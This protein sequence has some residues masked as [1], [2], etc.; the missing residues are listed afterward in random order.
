[1]FYKLRKIGLHLA[2][3]FYTISIVGLSAQVLENENGKKTEE[4]SGGTN[5]CT[6]T[7]DVPSEK[8]INQVAEMTATLT[9][10]TEIIKF[11]ITGPNDYSKEFTSEGKVST[12]TIF[13]SFPEKGNYSIT[14]TASGATPQQGTILIY[15]DYT[16]ITEKDCIC[17]DSQVKAWLI[18]C[19]GNLVDADWRGDDI[20]FTE[21]DGKKAV[22]TAYSPS[23]EAGDKT[24]IAKKNG[25]DYSK[26]LT[27][28]HLRKIKPEKDALFE[29]QSTIIRST[30]DPDCPGSKAH[31]TTDIGSFSPND[32][33]VKTIEENNPTWYAPKNIEGFSVTANIK[34]LDCG[35][36]SYEKQTKIKVFNKG[37][38]LVLSG[39]NICEN[40][41]VTGTAYRI[42]PQT[43]RV[44]TPAVTW[45]DTPDNRINFSKVINTPTN[46]IIANGIFEDGEVVTITIIDDMGQTASQNVTLYKKTKLTG[47]PAICKFQVQ[48]YELHVC[49]GGQYQLN[50]TNTNANFVVNG[51]IARTLTPNL[52]DNQTYKFQVFGATP[53]NVKIVLSGP[54]SAELPITITDGALI[55]GPPDICRNKPYTY[56]ATVC[57]EGDY[58]IESTPSAN[59]TIVDG[60]FT[61]PKG[62]GTFKFTFQASEVDSY[63][64]QIHKEADSDSSGGP[65]GDPLTVRVSTGIV[66][67]K[68]TNHC[69]TDYS[70]NCLEFDGETCDPALQ[71]QQL[72]INIDDPTVVR[73]KNGHPGTVTGAAFNFELVAVGEGVAKVTV[74]GGGVVSNEITVTVQDARVKQFDVS[75]GKEWMDYHHVIYGILINEEENQVTMQVQPKA[76]GDPPIVESWDFR[77]IETVGPCGETVTNS[78]INNGD[79]LEQDAGDD[80]IATLTYK[81]TPRYRYIVEC[82]IKCPN[83]NDTFIVFFN[84][85][86]ELKENKILPFAPSSKYRSVGIHGQ[87]Q[88]AS[89][90][91]QNSET[92]Q[93]GSGFS[94]DAYNLSATYST[95][96]VSVPLQS[97]ELRLE[98]RRT[99]SPDTKYSNLCSFT[100]K[101]DPWK[102]I[103]GL[104][105]RT[106]ITAR[107]DFTEEGYTV[108]DENGSSY[109][110]DTF[111]N[112]KRETFSNQEAA[113]HNLEV[114]D[115]G[116]LWTKRYGTKYFFTFVPV[117]DG[118]IN[119]SGSGDGDDDECFESSGN[120]Q[121]GS[122]PIKAH[123][124]IKDITDRNNNKLI[125]E[126]TEGLL[127][128]DRI[129]YEQAPQLSIDFEY[130]NG[131]LHTVTDPMGRVHEYTFGATGL[132]TSVKQPLVPV[133]SE[134][135]PK[136]DPELVHPEYFYDYQTLTSSTGNASKLFVCL[137]KVTDPELNEISLDYTVLFANTSDSRVSL[138]SITSPDGEATFEPTDLI[139]T[140][141]NLITD[142][143]GHEWKY[144][145]STSS[146]TTAQGQEEFLLDQFTRTLNNNLTMTAKFGRDQTSST[147]N[148]TEV[149]DYHGNK[150]QYQY[151][152]HSVTYHKREIVDGLPVDSTV[153]VDYDFGKYGQ[154]YREVID[155]DGL[156][157]TKE[158]GY[159][160]DFSQMVK[161]VDPRGFEA[162]NLPADFTTTYR[163]DERGN[164]IAEFAPENKTTLFAF[165]DFGFQIAVI[166]ADGRTT[167]ST[168]TYDANG[169][170][171][172]SVVTGYDNELAITTSKECD[173][174]GNVLK[175]VDGNGNETV[176]LFDNLNSLMATTFPQVKDYDKNDNLDNPV[177]LF[178]RDK[179]RQIVGKLDPRGNWI[180]TKYDKMLRP[181]Q[182]TVEFISEPA[183]NIVTETFYDKTGN[184][185]EFIDARGVKYTFAYD[186]FNNLL[187]EV[188]DVGE[189]EEF[190][191]LTSTYVYGDDSG[192]DLFGDSGFVPTKKT[193]ARG[194]VTLLEYDDAYRLKRTKRGREGNEVLLSQIDYDAAGN[195]RRTITFNDKISNFDGDYIDAGVGLV[196]GDQ[197]TITLYDNLNRPI[198]TAVNLNGEEADFTDTG[199]IITQTFYDLAGNVVKV[200]DPE[201]HSTQTEYDGAG[202]VI[203]QVVNLDYNET[204]KVDNP[205]ITSAGG[206][207]F[208][209]VA[210]AEDIVTSKTYDDNSN[211]LTETIHNDTIG[212]VGDQVVTKTY[213]ALN[214]VITVTDPEGYPSEEVGAQFP[215]GFFTET[216]YDLNN[217]VRYV[218][219]ARGFETVTEYDEAN[220][221]FKQILPA[222]ENAEAAF[223]PTLNGGNGGFPSESPIVITHFDTNSNVVKTVDARGLV[224]LNFY[225]NLNRLEETRQI[226]DVND[227]TKDLV[228]KNKYD[229]N[230][231]LVKT[232]F[233]R[234][235]ID[236]DTNEESNTE[237][238]TTT[239]Y[240]SLDRPLITTDPEG[241]KSVVFCDLVG[242]KVKLFDKRANANIDESANTVPQLRYFTQVEFDLANRMV[243]NT[244]PLIPVAVRDIME[245]VNINDSQPFSEVKYLK[246]NWVTETKDLNG[247]I[248]ET[249]YDGAGRKKK[250]TT[251]IDQITEFE[252]DKSSNVLKQTVYNNNSGGN[253]ITTYEYDKRNLLLKEKLNEG[254]ALQR[255]YS[256]RYDENGNKLKR[257]FPNGDVTEYTYDALDRLR[258]EDYDQAESENREYLYNNNGA[259]VI[260]KDETG[261]TE[262]DH[263]ILGR[264]I[265]ETKKDTLGNILTIVESIYD[266]ANNRIRCFFPNNKKTLVSF[267][268]KRNLIKIMKG[269]HGK[270]SLGGESGLPVETTTY[271]YN[272]NGQQVSCTTPNGQTTTKTY[273][274]AD[275]ILTSTTNAN[276]LDIYTVTYKRDAVGNQL[277]TI[278]TRYDRPDR[279]LGFIYDNVYRLI[280]EID[281]VSGAKIYTEYEYDL[282][283][284]RLNK[285]IKDANKVQTAI[286]IYT[287]DKLNRT[288]IVEYK[289][290][291]DLIKTY[292]YD[293]DDN[294]NRSLKKEIDEVNGQTVVDHTYTYD[295]ENRLKTVEDPTGV[296]FTASYDY[297][298][299]RT[300][301]EEGTSQAQTTLKKT[302]YIYDGGVTCQETE[303]DNGTDILVKQYI[304][305]NGMGGGIGSVLY[306]ERVQDTS[307]SSAAIQSFYDNLGQGTGTNGSGLIAEYYAY[308]AVGSVV[309]NT[310]QDGYVIREN[311][312]DAYGNQIREQDWSS[313]NFPIEFGGSQNDLLFSTKERDFST[314][315]DYFGY[316]YYDAV[317][318]KFTTRDPS[319][320]PDGPNNY[321]Y[322][323]NNPI[324]SLD[325]L[326]LETADGRAF[327]GWV[328]TFINHDTQE[329]YVGSTTAEIRRFDEDY[330]I[331]NGYDPH[332]KIEFINQKNTE[333][334]ID[335][336]YADRD[337]IKN[338]KG[339][340]N[341]FIQPTVA[342]EQERINQ[343]KYEIAND[344]KYKDYTLLNKPDAMNE[345]KLK[346]VKEHYNP[347]RNDKETILFKKEGTT[348]VDLTN[349]RK[350]RKANDIRGQVWAE[351]KEREARGKRRIR[352]VGGILGLVVS[353]MAL[354][355][356]AESYEQLDHRAISKAERLVKDYVENGK[357]YFE[358]VPYLLEELNLKEMP[359]G[360]VLVPSLLQQ[361]REEY[362][363]NQKNKVQEE[364]NDAL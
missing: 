123:Y 248:T 42:N 352:R 27:V 200:I 289:E 207:D 106:N 104:G 129:Y 97:S 103:M 194:L 214:R 65:V 318:G 77:R 296:I 342:M 291:N 189:G 135:A 210:A 217:N 273:D 260:A 140:R 179:N 130:I 127:F 259:V 151:G 279:K 55:S 353:W 252:Y 280:T 41:K 114:V 98:F 183:K 62:G 359:G 146:F 19:E 162:G 155:P 204:T 95:T 336:V 350:F 345:T 364:K 35:S 45:I 29:G 343:V 173:L 288:D 340:Q 178:H 137:S 283:G 236:P 89:R 270:V 249:E 233:I 91:Q 182:V 339:R 166:D 326:G 295:R 286:Y 50:L 57:E 119:G 96:D 227:D 20:T 170:I 245:D 355:S 234:N 70:N 330:Q 221:A 169:W 124:R 297:R 212:A 346:K 25:K 344:P 75:K 268:D 357:G 66:L 126:Y 152:V 302:N 230:N 13:P 105:W 11:N 324:N 23:D 88:T 110:Y 241:F 301:K 150:V 264:Q 321:L 156:A 261:S 100:N 253:Q 322:V 328:Y 203:K 231:N 238:I 191:N 68:D 90:P 298:T 84:F 244:L 115:G 314:G 199:D 304:R 276:A 267:Y 202:R 30:Y 254:E 31:F 356:L 172:T 309:A 33:N 332:H 153:T 58:R 327:V 121:P 341:D 78:N 67:R 133:V 206:N 186:A 10:C 211:C 81:I 22:F 271:T 317:L 7:L 87:P 237:L 40:Q 307:A 335:P 349:V 228:S 313:D 282:Q 47:A 74:S 116:L 185:S 17:V 337:K 196:S 113:Q 163:L 242:N 243:K 223:D 32:P 325:P 303:D 218:K 120:D 157:I 315:L 176:N 292:D 128:P 71:N 112:P 134:D 266:K 73:L 312:F 263:D 1:M 347:S 208:V 354:N 161:I 63:D 181:T 255:I 69:I 149:V 26:T 111:L 247:N 351:F 269:Y 229:G 306:M 102:N 213:D 36:Y 61:A 299:R 184:K 180:F 338:P 80:T 197:E 138:Q 159:D 256:Y 287:N 275:R 60:T 311:D 82:K 12:F 139:N 15:E 54:N 53:G 144:I 363:E 93:A 323:N 192:N 358:T 43:N 305:G 21:M 193:D 235:D 224:T 215:D 37:L 246:N 284:N 257:T 188:K 226:V 94:I 320:Y 175:T 5:P 132:L 118:G 250:I 290:G 251:A 160:P 107:V 310:D 117:S 79:K 334:W 232:T 333:G 46:D 141:T 51:D 360:N 265:K 109:E 136:A 148:L 201:G 38:T 64:L 86:T 187:T 147:I 167:T 171:D 49:K 285:I 222:V 44:E 14:V 99:A 164:R 39:N 72:S 34:A 274:K 225:D 168:R 361:N 2:A 348:S 28:S 108:I 262:Y 329:V 177:I 300:A 18:D 122:F 48:D 293:Y 143:R 205:E 281:D 3:L 59:T 165:N 76:G 83:T 316:R 209:I 154:P 190:L 319:G 24:I 219:N 198:K 308:N 331:K 56:F 195:V 125:Y 158:F 216:K 278:E 4:S 52:N 85:R 258:L 101:E 8:C 220:R 92:D 145:F 9:K 272:G 6:L 131:R 294:G 142:T 174:V 362:L 16:V 277:E 239:E 240:D